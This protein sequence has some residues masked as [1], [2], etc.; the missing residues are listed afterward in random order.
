MHE[1]PANCEN[2][3]NIKGDHKKNPYI[4][5]IY[6]FKGSEGVYPYLTLNT[7]LI[8]NQIKLINNIPI[9]ENIK[10]SDIFH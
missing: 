5:S 4:G 1:W 3:E 7:L 10:L 2:D 6:F 8:F 9:K